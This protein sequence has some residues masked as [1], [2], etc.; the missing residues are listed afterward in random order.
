MKQQQESEED[1]DKADPSPNAENAALNI[2]NTIMCL[3]FLLCGRMIRIPPPQ[4]VSSGSIFL[5]TEFCNLVSF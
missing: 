1:L 2:L 3:S 5:T 4:V